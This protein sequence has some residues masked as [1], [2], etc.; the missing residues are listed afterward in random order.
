[1]PFRAVGASGLTYEP[2]IAEGLN[3]VIDYMKKYPY[4]CMEQKISVAVALRDAESLE[5]R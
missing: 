4:T 1:M 5:K 2:K 3:G